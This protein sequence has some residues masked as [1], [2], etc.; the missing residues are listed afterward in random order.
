MTCGP[1]CDTRPARM[2]R[3]STSC[4]SPT[5]RTAFAR[6]WPRS[7]SRRSCPTRSWSR[8]GST[9]CEAGASTKSW[10]PRPLLRPSSLA[11]AGAHASATRDAANRA[12]RLAPLL[13]QVV[14]L[15]DP[16]EQRAEPAAEDERAQNLAVEGLHGSDSAST[17]VRMCIEVGIASAAIRNMGIDLRSALIAVAEHLLDA[18]QVGSALEQ[19]RGERVPQEVRVDPLRV[20]PG[21]RR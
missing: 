3:T 6:A 7:A 5:S 15:R 17:G 16:H 11:V 18:S 2:P 20:E 19:V 4:R 9:T 12:A 1:G 14:A 21:L 13:E 8:A 10:Q